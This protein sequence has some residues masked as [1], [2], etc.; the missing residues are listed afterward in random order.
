MN[1]IERKP[2]WVSAAEL[3]ARLGCSIASI[4]RMRVGGLIPAIRIGTTGY[5]YDPEAVEA[6]LA[7]KR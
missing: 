4:R 1:T 5:R 6:A 2:N 7:V 3:A